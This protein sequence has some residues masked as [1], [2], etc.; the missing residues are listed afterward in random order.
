VFSPNI[1]IVY[2]LIILA[3]ISQEIVLAININIRLRIS[4]FFT[5]ILSDAMYAL[6]NLY[7]GLL[8][9]ESASFM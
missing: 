7:L 9:V 8:I 3:I 1:I 2:K 5:S 6:K 4:S